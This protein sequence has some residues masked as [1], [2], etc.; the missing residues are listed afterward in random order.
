MLGSALH[1]GL[2]A[3]QR[4][5]GA[6]QFVDV[7]TAQLNRERVLELGRQ[8]SFGDGALAAAQDFTPALWV[9]AAQP[10]DFADDVGLLRVFAE[11][12]REGD[13]RLLFV[14]KLVGVQLADLGERARTLG[15]AGGLLALREQH[16]DQLF[17]LAE[18][19]ARFFE[20][21]LGDL[22]FGVELE[23][24]DVQRLGQIDLLRALLINARRA[25][26]QALLR[27]DRFV[28]GARHRFGGHS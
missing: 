19:S 3:G 11:R 28:A 8:I 9:A 22:I 12:L 24:F 25:E 27:V 16:L 20:R 21:T 15:L 14:G 23:D 1:D 18:L 17:E 26:Q 5:I 10:L 6:L 7:P 2:K 4:Q 13:Q